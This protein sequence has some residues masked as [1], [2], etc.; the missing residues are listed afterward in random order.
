MIKETT[1]DRAFSPPLKLFIGGLRSYNCGSFSGVSSSGAY[2][3]NT[4]SSNFSKLHYCDASSSSINMNFCASCY[5][6][7]CIKD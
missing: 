5:S 1:S 6:I 4:I 2:W 3:T 7:R